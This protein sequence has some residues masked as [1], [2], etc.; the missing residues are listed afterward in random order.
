MTKEKSAFHVYIKSKHINPQFILFFWSR[1][2]PQFSTV[3]KSYKKVKSKS[4]P[5]SPR[6]NKKKHFLFVKIIKHWKMLFSHR[7]RVGTSTARKKSCTRNWPN[8]PSGPKG[9]TNKKLKKNKFSK[10]K[11]RKNHKSCKRSILFNFL[12]LLLFI[13]SGSCPHPNAEAPPPRIP[14]AKKAKNL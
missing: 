2:N 11:R 1:I 12:Q 8:W 14:F 10:K 13:A 3:R 7:R 4:V 9:Y 6:F 5:S